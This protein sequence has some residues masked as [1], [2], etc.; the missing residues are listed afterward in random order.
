[1][2]ATGSFGRVALSVRAMPVIVPV[3]YRVEANTLRVQLANMATIDTLAGSVV[4]FQADGF[5]HE[6]QR[7]WSVHAV[8]RIATRDTFES[9]PD[10]MTF[11]IHPL[12]IEGRWLTFGQDFF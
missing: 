12:H 4:A 9:N 5:D 1:M 8:G 11:E 3:R 6:T 2:L 10:H 7:D